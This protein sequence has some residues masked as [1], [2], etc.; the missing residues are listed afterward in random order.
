MSD[1]AKGITS[2]IVLSTI[3]GGFLLGIIGGMC[4]GIPQYQVYQKGQAGQAELRKAE[5]NRKIA[6][7]EARA[8]LESAGYKAQAEVERARG[9]AEANAIIGDSLRDNEAY[10]RYLW[11]IG[12]HD[13][14]SETI[15][16]PTEANLPILEAARPLIGGGGG[17]Q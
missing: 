12:L 5:H 10:L 7:E 17:G 2:W 15:Y 9:V 11:I 3:I 13:G 14:T 6:I 16:I 1:T 4:Y 8:E